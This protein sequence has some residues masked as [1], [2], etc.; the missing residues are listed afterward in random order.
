ME[1]FLQGRDLWDLLSDDD[2]EIPKATLENVE[3]QRK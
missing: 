2:T 3:A 1:A